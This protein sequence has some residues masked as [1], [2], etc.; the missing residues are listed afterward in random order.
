VEFTGEEMLGRYLDLF[1]P[2]NTF[3]NAKFGRKLEYYQ[4]MEC[5]ADFGT[6]SKDKKYSRWAVQQAGRGWQAACSDP[7]A[8]K[9]PRGVK[10]SS[11]QPAASSQ[12]PA[13]SS[14]QPAGELCV[15]RS[16][17]ITPSLAS[18]PR[19]CTRCRQ[20]RQYLES[21]LGYLDSFYQRTQPLAQAD[22]QF[23][24]LEAELEEKWGLGQ[25]EG[26]ED[27]GRG[28]LPP[29]ELPIDLDVFESPEELETIGGGLLPAACCLLPAAGAAVALKLTPPHPSGADQ[30]KEALQAMGL[31]C[32]GT[33]RQRAERLFLL[34]TQVLASLDRKHFAASGTVAMSEEDQAKQEQV[35]WG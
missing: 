8:P 25:V 27:R 5:F 33:P 10:A 16:A 21:L 20:Y 30:L 2:Y 31:K 28:T 9:R 12:Q 26:W 1:Q 13:A 22:K 4:Y 18:G 7:Q 14:Q 34:K 24:K 17:A 3:T 35:G 19:P 11:Q 15:A 23:G 32:G 6:I 29:S